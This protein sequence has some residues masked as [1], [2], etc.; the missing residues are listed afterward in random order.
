MN[1][2]RKIDMELNIF[3]NGSLIDHLVVVN[4]SHKCF[5]RMN[6]LV[7][8]CKYDEVLIDGENINDTSQ[9]SV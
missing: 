5:N 6:D 2:F 4:R 7:E 3:S 8:I 1:V 9:I